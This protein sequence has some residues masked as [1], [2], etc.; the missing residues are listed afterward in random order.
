MEEQ[1]LK[2]NHVTYYVG[3]ITQVGVYAEQWY[4]II[5]SDVN[6]TVTH[7]PG[8][9]PDTVTDKV[10]AP[11][12]KQVVFTVVL[13]R[14]KIESKSEIKKLLTCMANY[15]V[16]VIIVLSPYTSIWVTR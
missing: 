1:Y 9:H 8:C 13:R 12:P 15:Y 14:H 11:N 7:P 2:N 3:L 5:T 10:V 16:T 6:W 4:V